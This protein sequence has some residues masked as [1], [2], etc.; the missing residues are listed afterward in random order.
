MVPG[1]LRNEGTLYA[2]VTNSLIISISIM[3]HGKRNV[4]YIGEKRTK[5]NEEQDIN[6]T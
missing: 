4:T 5:N 2:I 3:E 6:F 1:I